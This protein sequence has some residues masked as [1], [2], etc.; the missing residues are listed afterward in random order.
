MTGNIQGIEKGRASTAY[1]FA[2][3]AFKCH[4]KKA[5]IPMFKN[6]YFEDDKYKSYVKKIP[7]MIKTNGLAAT[8]AFVLSKTKGTDKDN[9]KPGTQSNP[10]NAYDL[11]Y[12]QVEYWLKTEDRKFLLDGKESEHLMKA[13]TQLKSAQY[14]VVT[15]EVLALFNWLRRFAEGLIDGEE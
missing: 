1:A 15:V 8:F 6:L 10:M 2:E 7:M 14:R 3:D 11:I 5:M 13:L 12:E 9:N 4:K